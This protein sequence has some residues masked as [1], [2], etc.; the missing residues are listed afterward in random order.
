MYIFESCFSSWYVVFIVSEVGLD[1]WKELG[2]KG[3]GGCFLGS[4]VRGIGIGVR[5]GVGRW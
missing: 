1:L 4:R 3:L 2:W 5:S